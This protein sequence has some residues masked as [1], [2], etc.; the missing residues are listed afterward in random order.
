MVTRAA[1]ALLAMAAS[2]IAALAGTNAQPF[3]RDEKGN[4][5]FQQV[6]QVEGATATQLHSRAKLWVA[7][8]Y[9]SAPDVVKLDDNEQHHMVLKGMHKEIYGGATTVWYNYTLTIECKDGRYRRTI[10]Q[11]LY[12]PSPGRSYPI[13]KN[14]G[15]DG[16]GT[17]GQKAISEHFRLAM[18]ALLTSLDTAMLKSESGNEK[19]Q[20]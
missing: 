13:E 20:W 2:A 17:F 5:C 7:S 15:K 19:D 3:P 10:D 9:R 14:L 1:V 6:V 18:V 16:I 4:V 11:I 8:S 12:E